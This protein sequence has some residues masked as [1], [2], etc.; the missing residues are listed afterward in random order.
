MLLL[1]DFKLSEVQSESTDKYSDV[2][3]SEVAE[4]D[5]TEV[6][7]R[8][9]S[10]PSKLNE[11]L[12][13]V[14]SEMKQQMANAQ[15]YKDV[16]REEKDLT[17][18]VGQESDFDVEDALRQ[19]LAYY[20]GWQGNELTLMDRIGINDEK[21]TRHLKVDIIQDK[22]SPSILNHL[23]DILMFFPFLRLPLFTD[24]FDAHFFRGNLLLYGSLDK[25]HKTDLRLKRFFGFISHDGFLPLFNLRY[26]FQSFRFSHLPL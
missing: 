13:P 14:E 17:E 8:S 22:F 26:L 24:P 18:L 5:F 6:Y 9:I 11:A 10:H 20:D 1:S 16:I 7:M 4:L 3:D 2:L 15:K 21:V 23:F 12:Y 19:V 25:T